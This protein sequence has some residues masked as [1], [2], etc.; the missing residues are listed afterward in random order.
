[1]RISRLCPPGQKSLRVNVRVVVRTRVL[2]VPRV[3]VLLRVPRVLVLRVPRVLVLLRVPVLRVPRVLVLLRVPRVLGV[4]GVI[5]ISLSTSTSTSVHSHSHVRGL[6]LCSSLHSRP[7]LGHSHSQV[8]KL[9]TCLLLQESSASEGQ[10]HLHL[11]NSKR[12]GK[13]HDLTADGEQ[14]GGAGV[15]GR[16][17]GGR[18]AGGLGGGGAGGLGTVGNRS[19]HLQFKGLKN[20]PGGHWTATGHAHWHVVGLNCCVPGQNLTWKHMHSHLN[21]LKYCPGGHCKWFGHVHLQ[22]FGSATCP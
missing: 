17:V 10:T 7:L 11:E 5:S 3:L 16:G 21:G 18:G 2:R 6:I 15:G 8:S 13:R 19:S 4:L 14:V 12:A 22:V 9:R 1:M 20:W